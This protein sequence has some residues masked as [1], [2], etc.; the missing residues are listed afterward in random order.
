LKR[1]PKVLLWDAQQAVEA[2]VT[3]LAGKTFEQFDADIV[4]HSAVER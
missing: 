4:L 2:I 1:D 3:M